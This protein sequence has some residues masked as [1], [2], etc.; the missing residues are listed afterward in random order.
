ML[1]ATRRK[2]INSA[3]KRSKMGKKK[4]ME[5]LDSQNEPQKHVFFEFNKPFK[6]VLGTPSCDLFLVHIKVGGPE[7]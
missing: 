7:A 6:S 3:P 4:N 5:G 2:K 1:E